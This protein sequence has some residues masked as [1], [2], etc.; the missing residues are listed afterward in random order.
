MES[1]N[2]FMGALKTWITNQYRKFSKKKQVKQS[3]ENKD[4]SGHL[5]GEKKMLQGMQIAPLAPP[6]QKL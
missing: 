2:N 3:V 4:Y 6:V 1:F 5:S